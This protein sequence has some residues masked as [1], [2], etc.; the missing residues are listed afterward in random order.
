MQWAEL[1]QAL[2]D[3]ALEMNASG[4]NQGTSGNLSVRA[5]D[6]FLVTPSGVPYDR[7]A[8]EDL[9]WMDLDGHW[10]GP[11]K[12]SSEWRFHLDIYRQRPDAGAVLHAHS[13][14]AT[15]L[16]CLEQDLPAFHYMVAVAGG[17]NIRCTPYAIFGSAE[18]S[19]LALRAL[20]GRK[21]CLLG[22]HGLLCLESDLRR[23]LALAAEVEHLCRVYLLCRQQGQVNILSDEEMARVLEQFRHYGPRA[24][25][26]E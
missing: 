4:I 21:A 24:Q 19:R 2:I 11:L 5:G 7:L 15:A 13:T 16:A 14:H 25:E 17:N 22:H 8:P 6:G 18:L 9:P 1:R 20:E 10:Q 12:P 26:P 23:A 3:T